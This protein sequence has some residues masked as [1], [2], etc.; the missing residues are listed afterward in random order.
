VVVVGPLVAHIDHDK[1]RLVE[2]HQRFHTIPD[3]AHLRPHCTQEEVDCSSCCSM[4]VGFVRSGSTVAAG[5]CTLLC[6][7]L[8]ESFPGPIQYRGMAVR[9]RDDAYELRGRRT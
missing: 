7:D 9:Q 2:R 5:R 1:R 8:V 4:V 3:F 6:R